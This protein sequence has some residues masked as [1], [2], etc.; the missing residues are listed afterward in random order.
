M[1]ASR[2]H[3]AAISA[4]LSFTL[5]LGVLPVAAAGPTLPLPDSIAAVGDSI[6]QA[7]SSAGSLGTDAPQNSWATGTSA[8]V[9]SHASRLVAA[10]ATTLTRHNLSVSG[11]KMVDLP[12]QM[13]N[14]AAVQPDYL[15]VLIGGNDV[16]TSTEASM[17]DPAA[18]EANFRQAISN[19][20]AGSPDT[21]IYVVS[22]PRVMGLWELFRNNFWARFIWSVGSVC[23]SLLASPTSTNQAD[24]DRRARVDARNQAFN[25]I[26][27]RVC[28]E[29]TNCHHDGGA[30]FATT[31]ATADVSGD[32]FHPSAAGQAKLASVSWAAGYVWTAAPPPNVAPN[33]AFTHSCTDLACIFDDTSTD[34]DGTIVSR[35]WSFGGSGDPQPH[36]FT[37]AGTHAV[38]L[39]VTD[40][41]GATASVSRSVMVTASPPPPTPMW[42]GGLASSAS[43]GRNSWTATV[44][45]TVGDASGPVVG[46]AV[47]GSWTAGSGTSSCTTS[48]AGT[49]Q[50]TVTV[51]KKTSSTRYS[52]SSLAKP[53]WAYRPA[54]NAVTS[55]TI[56]RP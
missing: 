26:L 16:C 33:A 44:T 1:R 43:A 6:T 29:T 10:G 47:S 51:N 3:R 39:T 7:A 12:G 35:A 28:A 46:A 22:I 49:C 30:A 53:G 42:V 24:V 13:L 41:D 45:I 2:A 8:S 50:I 19:L 4:A 38:T 48:S 52:V 25:E 15:T 36:T 14:A 37:A 56:T 54:S 9:N 31:F 34:A 18:F 32:Y 21:R 27:A 17:T 23:Q 55:V 40:D 20:R 5:L 11:A